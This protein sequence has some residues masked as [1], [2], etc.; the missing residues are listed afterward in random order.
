MINP[1]FKIFS[2]NIFITSFLVFSLIFSIYGTT[3]IDSKKMYDPL[4]NVENSNLGKGVYINSISQVYLSEM[5]S[6][7][8]AYDKLQKDGKLPEQLFDITFIIDTYKIS[9][10]KELT[11][12]VT[13][14]SFGQV[15]TPVN[16]TFTLKDKSSGEILRKYPGYI[17]V[18][19]EMVGLIYFEEL[20]D[21]TLPYGDYIITYRSVYNHDVVDEFNQEFTIEP[22]QNFMF[23]IIWLIA[24]LTGFLIIGGLFFFF[25]K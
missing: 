17:V 4:N 18:Q 7:I 11:G 14:T 1:I 19:T 9:D 12:L 13:Y 2:R 6:M 25:R 3:D 20:H 8:D 24:G 22:L 16:Y 5:Q 15:P 10:I 23:D 21:L